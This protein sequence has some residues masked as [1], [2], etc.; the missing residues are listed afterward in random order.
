MDCFDVF[1]QVSSCQE[2]RIENVKILYP[3]PVCAGLL[4]Y[5]RYTVAG[6]FSRLFSSFVLTSAA[7]L[8]Y[9][10]FNEFT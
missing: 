2:K 9:N 1:N 6:R 7:P 3:F 4:L 10:K 5:R 8:C